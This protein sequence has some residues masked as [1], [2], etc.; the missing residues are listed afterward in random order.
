MSQDAG[1]AGQGEGVASLQQGGVAAEGAENGR[2]A[3]ALGVCG[4]SWI[5]GQ[6]DSLEA[7]GAED[8]EAFQHARTLATLVVLVVADGTLHLCGLTRLR[9][10]CRCFC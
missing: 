9:A 2:A 10:E 7:L 8:V 3:R 6:L 5:R 4:F 1:V